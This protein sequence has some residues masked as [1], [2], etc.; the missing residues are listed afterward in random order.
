MRY[1]QNMT[2][3]ESVDIVHACIDAYEA[4]S[5]YVSDNDVHRRGKRCREWSALAENA[6]PPA[7]GACKQASIHLSP[8][9][10]GPPGLYVGSVRVP[11]SRPASAAQLASSSRRLPQPPAAQP[12]LPFPLVGPMVCSGPSGHTSSSPIAKLISLSLSYTIHVLW[13]SS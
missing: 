5:M 12:A 4:K 9:R 6:K 2:N 11:P 13:V 10:T 1:V 7:T 8:A 3:A